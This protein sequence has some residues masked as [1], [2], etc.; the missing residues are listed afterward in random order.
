[1]KVSNTKLLG[2]NAKVRSAK[3]EQFSSSIK[4]VNYKRAV[5][6]DTYE[7]LSLS[8]DGNF[9][10][11]FRAY[12]DGMVYR[13]VTNQKDSLT[14]ENEIASFEFQADKKAYV[15]YVNDPHHN[16]I[17]ALSFENSYQHLPIKQVKSDTL[18]FLPILVEGEGNLKIAITE[19]DLEDYPGMFLKSNERGFKGVFAPFAL[20]ESPIGK[21]N[22]QAFVT[23]RASYIART[24][25][26]RSFP[27]RVFIVADEDKKLLDNDMVY[28]L[29]SPSRIKDISWVKPGKVAWDWW[30]N[31]NISGVDF[32]AGINTE[33]YKYY[34]DFAAAS[35]IEYIL[36]DE[37]WATSGDL[38]NV[39]PEINLP[40]I[41]RYAK[42][43]NVD[44]WLWAGWLPLQQKMD[45]AFSTYS[46]MGVVGF[47]VDFMD[48]DDQGMVQFFYYMAEKAAAYKLMLDLHGAYKPTGIQRTYPNIL[49]FEGVRGLENVKWAN[50]DFPE[51]VCTAPFIRMLAGPMDYTPG[52]MENETKENFRP[53]YSSPMSQGTRCHQLALYV[54][55]E[56]PLVML[57][58]NP[59]NYIKEKESTEFISSIPTVFDETVPL[60]GKVS[61]YAAIARRSGNSWYIGATTNWTSRK[62]TLDMSFL[63][64]G[65][66][67]M[68]I[69][70]D[71]INANREPTDYKRVKRSVKR[72]DKI[73]IELA[74]GGGWAAKIYPTK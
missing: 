63:K 49:N 74:Q 16:D 66:Y 13:I 40:E 56:S 24:S 58:D 5:V 68:E 27:W 44:V 61:E 17:F 7:Q 18:S 52:A 67:E 41:I 47:K 50:T 38:M 19:A 11:L 59:T 1:M 23:K 28:R 51:Y 35:K 14:I 6:D 55:F 71:G 32:K 22:R 26:K 46:K 12:N 34:I 39:V 73:E 33:T 60:A 25:G 70:Q 15:P 4:G 21:N 36:L 64:E 53:V 31:W 45:Q 9:Q 48:R 72:G 69:F 42:S 2:F 10:I 37:G 8:F 30:N 3:T 20:A 43:K 65:T 54:V 57:A 62:M 29:A